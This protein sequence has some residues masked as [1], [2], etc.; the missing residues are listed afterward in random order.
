MTDERR[1]DPQRAVDYMLENS[2]R[3]A[4][5]KANRVH[6][7]QFRKSKKALLMNECTEKSIAARE[8]YAYAHPEY[9]E[10]L[11]GLRA[12]TEQEEALKWRLTGA[13]LRVEVW[14]SQNAND[15]AQDK[16]FR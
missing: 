8:A 10:L 14:R 11:E 4:Q 9:I 16:T 15:R 7:E 5:A 3:Y 12:A 2:L 13:Q 6:I 1:I